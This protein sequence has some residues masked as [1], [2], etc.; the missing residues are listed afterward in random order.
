[1]HSPSQCEILIQDALTNELIL[2]S[3]SSANSLEGFYLEISSLELLRYF[4]QHQDRKKIKAVSLYCDF[5][6]EEAVEIFANAMDELSISRLYLRGTKIDD[7]I[8]NK[9]I[10][11]PSFDKIE[12]L[13]L[14]YNDYLS[15]ETIKNIAQKEKILNLSTL[16]MDFTMIDDEAVEIISTSKC[17]K[18]LKELDLTGTL[19][20]NVAIDHLANPSAV[21]RL[22]VFKYQDTSIANDVSVLAQYALNANFSGL[23]YLSMSD[24]P[25]IDIAD[26]NRFCQNTAYSLCL[27]KLVMKRCNLKTSHFKIMCQA[28]SL[29]RLETLDIS[30]NNLDDEIIPFFSRAKFLHTLK[31]LYIVRNNFTKKFLKSLTKSACYNHLEALNLTDCPSLKSM[32]GLGR[33][34][35]K[36]LKLLYLGKV[37]AKQR[38]VTS[39]MTKQFIH[40]EKLKFKRITGKFNWS[41]AIQDLKGSANLKVLKLN[42]VNIGNDALRMLLKQV[43]FPVLE[44]LKLRRETGF[45]KETIEIICFTRRFP[46]LNFLNLKEN[47]MCDEDVECLVDS[48]NFPLLKVLNLEGTNSKVSKGCISKII[49]SENLPFIEMVIYGRAEMMNKITH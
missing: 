35:T 3:I 11:Q 30:G 22:T 31:E 36:P 12:K 1:M 24:L 20:S 49:A 10:T 33:E 13:G 19:V 16:E 14:S 28:E 27:K 26:M 2:P 17:F 15:N 8:L 42:N 48:V 32:A 4:I 7:Q 44:R 25:E 29:A 45:N 34:K 23:K 6:L 43:E 39:F 21:P 46:R 37:E 18:N 5:H 9:I 40:I 41:L 38:E 47:E